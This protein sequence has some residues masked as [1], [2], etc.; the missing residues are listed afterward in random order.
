MIP[1]NNSNVGSE[2]AI[3]KNQVFTLLL[4]LIVVSGTLTVFLYRQSHLAGA[5]L[6]Q[7]KQLNTL[8]NQN[9][10]SLMNFLNQ[11]SLYADKHPDF[12][13]VLKKY[14]VVPVPP[15]AAAPKK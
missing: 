1:D 2:I 7:A 10:A 13:P 11:L 5:D 4:A 15:G 6:T 9:E 8:M 14:G 12:A 3:L